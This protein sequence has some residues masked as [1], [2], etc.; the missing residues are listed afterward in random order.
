[1]RGFAAW[2]FFGLLAE[3]KPRDSIQVL[4]PAGRH[5]RLERELESLRLAR[6]F[7]TRT[8]QPLPTLQLATRGSNT[9]PTTYTKPQKDCSQ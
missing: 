4:E 5:R 8:N 3:S 7:E 9:I 6:Y 1:M 2:Q